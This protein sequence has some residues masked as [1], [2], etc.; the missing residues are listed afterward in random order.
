MSGQASNHCVEGRG[1]CFAGWHWDQLQSFGFG[2]MVESLV[3]FAQ[4]IEKVKSNS[5]I[6]FNSSFGSRN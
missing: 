1:I 3:I 5:Q 4:S 2:Q 6:L